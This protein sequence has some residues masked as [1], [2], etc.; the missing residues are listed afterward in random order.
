MRH[1]KFNSQDFLR[2]M[3]IEK[4][5]KRKKVMVRLSSNHRA[6]MDCSCPGLLSFHC[7]ERE[8]FAALSNQPGAV[9]SS[10]RAV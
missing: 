10:L 4:D 1:V 6:M 7:Q 3:K 8:V 5:A 9:P 2:K